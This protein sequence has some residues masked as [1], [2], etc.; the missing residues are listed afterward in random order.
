MFLSFTAEVLIST[1]SAKPT[2]S[3]CKAK[4]ATCCNNIL[5]HFE[6]YLTYLHPRIASKQKQML[7]YVAV[8]NLTA[9]CFDNFSQVSAIASLLVSFSLCTFWSETM[10]VFSWKMNT[11]TQRKQENS[12]SR[13]HTCRFLLR[14]C[15]KTIVR[16]GNQSKNAMSRKRCSFYRFP[17]VTLQ[18]CMTFHATKCQ[19]HQTSLLKSEV[20]K[21]FCKRHEIGTATPCASLH[22]DPCN[23]SGQ[24]EASTGRKTLNKSGVYCILLH[25]VA[26]QYIWIPLNTSVSQ[27]SAIVRNNRG[28]GML[29]W[30]L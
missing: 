5:N 6:T 14:I 25:R 20:L 15:T 7:L 24:L 8:Y 30:F 23:I 16:S 4:K 27:Y 11:H 28:F 22:Q 19:T 21:Q 12:P 29:K 9:F 2:S 10:S 3:T 1:S 17:T 18:N 13:N 26:Y